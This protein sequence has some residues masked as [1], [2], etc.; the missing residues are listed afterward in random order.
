MPLSADRCPHCA[1]P[2]Y[3][4]N[5]DVASDPSEIAALDERYTAAMAGAA[6]NG[7][8]AIAGD[9]EQQTSS[10]S[11][12]VISRD[13]AEIL[14]LASSENEVYSTFYGLVEDGLR[15]PNGS[16]WDAVRPIVDSATFPY[17]RRDVRFGALTLGDDGVRHYGDCHMI[18]KT[19]MID[20]RTTFFSE[21]TA[22]FLV[23]HHFVIPR[24]H[25]ATWSQRGRLAVAKLAA[26]LTPSTTASDLAAI[27]KGDGQTQNEPF[28]EAHV[29]GPVTI[30][31]VEQVSIGR[32]GGRAVRLRALKEKL[33]KYGVRY[34][35]L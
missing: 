33:D 20:F 6:A 9:L 17:Y 1:R 14:R 23:K 30:R 8:G 24:G 13:S 16:D 25:R 35:M 22:A 28:V 26:L 2:S 34:V 19:D 15:L 3:F 31:T 29:Y 5:V 10:K 4:P 11:R 27:L 7:T 18:L 32:N 21:N 12:V